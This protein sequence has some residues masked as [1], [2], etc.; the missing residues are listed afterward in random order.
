[1]KNK[2]YYLLIILSIIIF[3]CNITSEKIDK[4]FLLAGDNKNEIKKVIDYFK[5]KNDKQQLE[6][7][8]YLI[9]NMAGKGWVEYKPYT[10][11]GKEALFNIFD[12][13]DSL[14]IHNRKKQLEDSL[15]SPISYTLSKVVED[16]KVIKADFLIENIE[17]A[18]KAWKEPWAK[19]LS[20]ELFCEYLLPYRFSTEPLKSWRKET[21]ENMRWLKDSMRGDE[22]NILKACSVVNDSLKRR[23]K[24]KHS[25]LDFYP[26][27][28]S[29]DEALKLKGGRCD[30]LNLI[31]AYWMR[32]IGIPVVNDFTPVWANS[33]FGG[34][35]WLS[36][37]SD[38]NKNVPFNAA[39]DNPIFDSLPFKKDKLCKVYRRQYKKQITS[40][41]LQYPNEKQY[42]GYLFTDN[43][44]D[45][46]KDYI[47]NM[48]I[49]IPISTNKNYL[50]KYAYLGVLCEKDWRI[51]D[52]GTVNSNK[53]SFKNV[54]SNTIYVAFYATP[55][56]I[57][58]LSQPFLIRDKS[59]VF[60]QSD[61]SIRTS[62]LININKE[63]WWLRK[64]RTYQ[65]TY[66]E[67][68]HWENI[69]PSLKWNGK[70][71]R[72]SNEA[73]GEKLDSIMVFKSLPSNSVFRFQ[74]IEPI[75]DIGTFG[76]PFLLDKGRYTTY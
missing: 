66:W 43:Y 62:L 41:R 54:G 24:F 71:W 55:D 60:F 17:Y 70:L 36:L 38:N 27:I 29:Y 74:N 16:I 2:N 48:D 4:A 20:F 51:V 5:N 9:E 68:D 11:E 3:S 69:C 42:P 34:H 73:E 26:F 65:L 61:T 12:Y 40:F 63:Y 67:Y 32:S 1:M 13:T 64:Q 21:S 46:T 8:Y 25:E 33:N 31:A 14:T 75:F 47:P 22:S 45:V 6:A 30:D 56:T 7:A 44:Y 39:Y 49:E 59:V 53:I 18:F 52:V 19:H 72:F 23:F 57:Q 50:L 35:T 28:L 15:K 10:N 58:I 76:R 37:L